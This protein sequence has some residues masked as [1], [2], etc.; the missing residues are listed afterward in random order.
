MYEVRMT[1][2][3]DAKRIGGEARPGREVLPVRGRRGWLETECPEVHVHE[4]RRPASEP[5]GS[6]AGVRALVVA[7]KRVTTVEPRGAGK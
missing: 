2:D 4:S 3:S 6:E 5:E 7:M 1:A